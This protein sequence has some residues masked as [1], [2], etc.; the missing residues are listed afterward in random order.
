MAGCGMHVPNIQEVG[1]DA[2][3][4]LLVKAIVESINCEL[5]QAIYTVKENEKKA[6]SLSR[7]KPVSFLDGWGVQASLTLQIEEKG[8]LSPTLVGFI[9]NPI[10]SIAGGG[11]VSSGATRIDKLNFYHTV[12][13]L[14]DTGPCGVRQPSTARGSYFIDSNLKI[15]EWL[16]TQVLL[17][18]TRETTVPVK[19]SSV[20]K[21]NA[22][23]HEVK[24]E[25]LTSGSV[26]P[27]WRLAR[28]NIN[29][30]GTFFSASRNRIHA[31]IL[32]FGPVDPSQADSLS[33]TAQAMFLSSQLGLATTNG[34]RSLTQP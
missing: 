13:D 4:M 10:F 31:L 18:G 17:V 14:Y 19:P 26:T 27:T 1:D 28:L 2:D 11:T 7:R 30:S 3:G 32:T 23:S 9:G 24:F 29:P 33:P 22:M 5:R 34:L 12:K 20:F 15:E 16:A 21:Q 8:T 6:A 25:V